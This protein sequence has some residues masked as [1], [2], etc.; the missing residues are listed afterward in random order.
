MQL[1]SWA[2]LLAIL[3][4]PGLLF[5]TPDVSAQ[6]VDSSTGLS[7]RVKPG[8]MLVVTDADGR[9]TKG[10][11]LEAANGT[12]LLSL[13][14]DRPDRSREA[15][16]TRDQRRAFTLANVREVRRHDGLANGALIGLAVGAGPAIGMTVY[17]VA[18][19]GNEGGS[20]CGT[21]PALGALFAVG[22]A[23]I[24]A[25]I[26]AAIDGNRVVYARRSTEFRLH[27]VVSRTERG[28]ALS[29]RF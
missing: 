29:I 22:G 9:Q 10:R 14:D 3:F 27:P 25:A 16:P 13:P 21:L 6:P 17:T 28:A 12:L 15:A 8:T 20:N 26:D 5:L 2:R 7:E 19:C 18:L 11:L 24:G 1:S 23:G 4:V